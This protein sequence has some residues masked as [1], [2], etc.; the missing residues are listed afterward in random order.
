MDDKGDVRRQTK[1][2]DTETSETEETYNNVL[3][4]SLAALTLKKKENDNI[5]I[6]PTKNRIDFVK[7]LIDK[8]K[9]TPLIDPDTS[10]TE[11]YVSGDFKKRVENIFT[12]LNSLGYEL[13]YI[14]SG[15]TGHTFKAYST[16]NPSDAIAIKVCAYPK[17]DDY[18]TDNNQSRP[19]N[20]EIYIIRCLS[21]FVHRQ[22]T[23]HIVIPFHTFKTSIK[24]FIRIDKTLVDLNDD[25]N[26]IYKKFIE[27]YE[28][29]EFE[30]FVSILISEWAEGG[31]LLDYIRKNYKTMDI[32]QWRIIFF[33]ILYTLA[34]IHEKFPSFRHNDLKANNILI[35]Y[36]NLKQT[37]QYYCYRLGK[38]KFIIPDIDIQIMIWDF[39]FASINGIFDNNKVNSEWA[40]NMNI[41]REEHKYYD[42]HYFFNTLT[43]KR[44]FPQFY[45]GN[46][47]PDKIKEFIADII[48]EEYRTGG[49]YVNKK[50][51]LQVNKEFTTPYKVLMRHDLFSKYRVPDDKK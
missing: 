29:G 24:P 41:T 17:N 33:Q 36:T 49:K 35:K 14:K 1:Y 47:V 28:D 10:D 46:Y 51:R 48:P 23:P 25:R 6:K 42:M 13:K 20:A 7:K 34:I 45:E 19:E 31:D 26:E 4:Q 40:N 18:G 12:V 5:K 32:Q 3:M 43:S 44:F 16:K 21:Y 2:V 37:K 27:K 50:G 8:G 39:D 22:M 30:N 15:T 11:V 9:F 38:R